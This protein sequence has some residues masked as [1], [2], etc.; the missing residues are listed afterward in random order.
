MEKSL[1]KIVKNILFIGLIIYIGID[2]YLNFDIKDLSKVE[3]DYTFFFLSFTS[4]FISQF[5]PIFG[6]RYLLNSMGENL[7][8]ID[9]FRI[10]FISNLGRYI[11]GKIWQVLGIIKM[12]EAVGIKRS[13]VVNSMIYAQIFSLSTGVFFG[14]VIFTH[15]ILPWYIL[16]F[17][18]SFFIIMLIP[19]FLI[20]SVN[21]FLSLLKKEP[22]KYKLKFENLFIYLIY[23]LANWLFIGFT[24]YLFSLSFKGFKVFDFRYILI[25]PSAWTVGLLAVFA[26]GGVGVR[27]K[28][29]T[30]SM[31]MFGSYK[32]FLIIPWV[33]RV[34]I[35]IVELLLAL[36]FYFGIRDFNKKS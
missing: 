30:E 28:I 29:L 17:L 12:S 24:F 31:E 33:Y 14:L 19:S 6:W 21:I 3:I 16:A 27:E 22:L 34:I 32:Y 20:R 36:V 26:P 2:L 18:G 11:P 15:K 13:N 4:M 1:V 8:V 25:L 5:I 23:I 9:S 10:W 35:T 7:S